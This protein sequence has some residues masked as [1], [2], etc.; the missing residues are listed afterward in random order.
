MR[1]GGR[2]RGSGERIL[3][4]RQPVVERGGH[5][6]GH[7]EPNSLAAGGEVRRVGPHQSRDLIL[8]APNGGERECAV[9]GNDSTV[10]CFG[11][12]VRLLDQRRGCP[13]FACEEVDTHT[14]AERERQVPECA[15]LTGQSHLARRQRVPAFVVPDEPGRPARQPEPAQPFLRSG[16][17]AVERSEGLAYGRRCRR[18]SL[19]DQ[20]RQPVEE[21]VRRSRRRR[22]R[23]RG[24]GRG[25]DL[26]RV[27]SASQSTG[28]H[29]G[30]QCIEV[31]L[32]RPPHIERLESSGR[33]EQQA[34][35]LATPIRGEGNSGAK[36]VDLGPLELVQRA[37][38]RLCNK[39]ERLVER[40]RLLLCLR[41]GES[42]AGATCGFGRQRGRAFQEGGGGGEAARASARVADRSS[43]AAMSSSGMTA[44]CARCQARR[45]GSISGSVASA[46]ARW[47]SLR[48]S[49]PEARYTADRTSG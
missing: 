21:E 38:L 7:G 27:A 5:P 19:G 10:R 43:S 13:Q 11:Q 40:T 36:H 34:W 35:C 44:A 42:P 29:G 25:R 2:V 24:A 32:T 4:T 33:R 37:C 15:D 22:R 39:R 31:D 16:L 23:R 46:R 48:A 12:S 6:L 14:G 18:V 20:Q 8:A 47:A 49:V 3:V 41:R 9:Q 26:S 30:G 17:V 1:I 45:S 28:E